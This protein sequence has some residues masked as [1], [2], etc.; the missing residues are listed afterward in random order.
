[1][2]DDMAGAAAVLGLFQALPRL[3]SHRGPWPHRRHENMPSAPPAAGDIVRALNGSPSRSEYRCRGPA[4]PGRRRCPTRQGDQ[5]RR[6]G[7]H[8]HLTGR[9]DRAGQQVTGSSRPG[10]SRRAPPR[11]RRG[12]GRADVAASPPR[13]LQGRAQERHRRLNNVSSQRARVHRGG[14]FSGSSPT[15]CRGRPRHRGHRAIRAGRTWPKGGTGVTV[16]TSSPT[17]PGPPAAALGRKRDGGAV[18]LHSHTTASDGTLSRG[19][20]PG[21]RRRGVRI[22]AV[23]DHDSTEAWRSPGGAETLRRSP[24]CPA[25]DQLRRRGRQ[26]TSRLM[27]GLRDPWFQEFCRAQRAERRERVYRM[28]ERLATLGMPIDPSGVRDRQGGSAGRPHVPRSWWSV[29]T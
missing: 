22:L 21:A 27:H 14:V 23:T 20:W 5:T 28:A 13:R 11:R 4:H 2:K 3:R 17:S 19:S 1:M 10:Q 25:R 15:G 26:I 29:A 9:G 12:G 8:G 18:D 24:S 16:R 7:R 6:D